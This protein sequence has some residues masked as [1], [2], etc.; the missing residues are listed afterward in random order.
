MT[1]SKGAVRLR[2]WLRDERRTQEW[3]ATEL[4]TRQTTVSRWVLGTG[5]PKIRFALALCR[6]TGISVELWA[7]TAETKAS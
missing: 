5:Q 4:G 6:I 7:E 3:L 2:Q 1:I